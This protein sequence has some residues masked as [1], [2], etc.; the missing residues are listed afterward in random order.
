MKGLFAFFSC[1]PNYFEFGTTELNST[2]ETAAALLSPHC[3]VK[4][5]EFGK[6]VARRLEQA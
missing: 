1:F 4:L 5:I 2:F 6:A 3:R